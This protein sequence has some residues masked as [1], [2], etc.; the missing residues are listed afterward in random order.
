MLSKGILLL[1]DMLLLTW[2]PLCTRNWQI[3]TLKFSFGPF[4][5]LLL[6]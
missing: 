5:L 3:F 1:Q 2:R 4:R 6:S